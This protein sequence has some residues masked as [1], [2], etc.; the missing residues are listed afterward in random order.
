ML[1]KIRKGLVPSRDWSAFG[2][3]RKQAKRYLRRLVRRYNKKLIVE[4]LA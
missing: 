1:V 4:Q 3:D 2:P